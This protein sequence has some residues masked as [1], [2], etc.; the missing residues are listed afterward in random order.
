VTAV[1]LSA[2]VLLTLT[3]VSV[4]LA[5]IVAVRELLRRPSAPTPVPPCPCAPCPCT[6]DDWTSWTITPD[7]GQA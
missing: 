4:A 1:Q 5:G 3:S 7:G 6:G 2:L